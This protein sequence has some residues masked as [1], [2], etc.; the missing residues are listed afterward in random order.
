MSIFSKWA[1]IATIVAQKDPKILPQNAAQQLGFYCESSESSDWAYFLFLY[2]S[3][4]VSF[5]K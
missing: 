2:P 4:Y 3:Y 1:G 5:T